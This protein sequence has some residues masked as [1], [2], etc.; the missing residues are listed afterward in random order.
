MGFNSR[1]FKALMR[2]N[3]INYKRTC[4][5]SVTEILCPLVVMGIVA[6]IRLADDPTFVDEQSIVSSSAMFSP[7]TMKDSSTGSY[8]ILTA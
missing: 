1:H 5:G 7:F 4:C 2:K 3:A 6:S 8:N